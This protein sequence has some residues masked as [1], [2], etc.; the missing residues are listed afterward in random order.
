MKRI[1][2]IELAVLLVSLVVYC[3]LAVWMTEHWKPLGDE[4][5]YLLAA[6]SL[7]ADRDLN[8]ANNY[9]QRDYISFTNGETLDAHVKILPDGAQVLNH[10]VGLPFVIALPYALGGRAGVEFFLALCGSLL[11]WQMF[12]LAF[13]VTRRALW[14]AL[15]ALVLAFTPPLLL[16]A[17]L[18]YPEVV[19]ALLFV[20]S[21]RL[22]L[23]KPS[24]RVSKFELLLLALVLVVLPWLSIRFVIL[25]GLLVLFAA[26]RW[27]ET[28]PRLVGVA[29]IAVVAVATYFFVNSIPLA[30][31]VPRGNPSE[32]AS[33]NLATLSAASISRGIAGWWIEPQR[34]TL[35]MA[36]VY[37]LALAGIPRL[38]C[39][40]FRTGLLLVS[41]LLVLIP[42]VALLG[43]F[44]I[45]FEVGARYFVV[46]LPLLTAPFAL[47]LKA[48]FEWRAVWQRFAFGAFAALLV[49][50]GAWNGIFMVTDASYAYGS[51]VSAY[52]RV[53][54]RDLSP[55]FAGLGRRIIVS[56]T[57]TQADPIASV[58]T[59]D[60]VPVWRVSQGKAGTILQSF[61]LTELTVGHYAVNF[62]ARAQ[63]A[64]AD[65]EL[66]SLDV[67][68]AEG[69][70]LVHS[71]WL[72]RDLYGDTLRR[73]SVEFDNPYFDRWGFPLTLQ[74]A[75]S[76]NADLLLSAITFEPE[77]ATTW[78][79]AAIWIMAILGL[80]ALLNWDLIV[81]RWSRPAA[82]GPSQESTDSTRRAR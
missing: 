21:T 78:V 80:L 48:G 81:P 64:A 17:T 1:T 3:A 22:I 10:D 4:P 47:M 55:L 19:G 56:P 66:V 69:L 15:A 53:A 51:V 29:G 59:Y 26:A 7:L 50:L 33:G 31:V 38:L 57:N 12:K 24:E 18:V 45:P 23:F 68:S 49:L 72:A 6:H 46:A 75:T 36:P 39:A 54:G 34:G 67:F 65:G 37:L 43:G 58:E 79:R 73:A 76:G 62:R 60:G 44:W 61:D 14:S 27:N 11:A 40:D 30:G 77:N 42:F 63:G 9:A 2:S 82:T 16:Y 71:G 28:R 20:W 41:P 52:S 74:V 5:H 35:V 32:L 70:P 13:D 25:E 8:L